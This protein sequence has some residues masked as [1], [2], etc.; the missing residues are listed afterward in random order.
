MKRGVNMPVAPPLR[1]EGGVLLCKPDV[2]V[3]HIRRKGG[4]LPVMLVGDKYYGVV[5]EAHLLLL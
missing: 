1:L 4:K 2:T 5:R 3:L